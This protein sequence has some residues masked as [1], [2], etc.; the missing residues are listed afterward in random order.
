MP[1]PGY[2]P[3]LVAANGK[4]WNFIIINGD[5]WYRDTLRAMPKFL[6]NY[7]ARGTYYP[8]ASVN[9][10]LCFPGRAATY[11]GWRV[12]RHDAVNNGSGTRYVASGALANTIPVILE[13]A[14]YW[15]GFIGKIYNGL[16]EGGGGGWGALPWK[17]PG[18]HYMAGQW[19]APNYFD[20]EEL[21]ADGTIRMTHGTAD[22]N[23][24]GTDYA[25]DVERLRCVEFFD[26]VPAGRPWSLILATKGTHQ[27][28]GGVA[29]P[30]ARY[31]NTAVTLTEDASFGLDLTTVGHGSWSQ[32]VATVPWDA[33]AVTA[34]RLGHTEALRTALA[35]D[36]CVD[37]I[38]TELIARSWDQNTILIIKCDNAHSGGEG[39]FDAK[40]VPHQSATD[41]VMWVYVPG[42]PG[43]TCRAP[44]SDIDVAPFVY[45]MAGTAPPIA[46]HGMSF[47][48]T[49]FDKGHPHR[50]AAP[51]SNP[52]KDSPVF[53][54]IQ[55]GGN[56]GRMYYRILPTSAK[57]ANQVGGY[58]DA[59]QTKNVITPGDALVLA[60]LE[61]ARS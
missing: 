8:C 56:P 9:T 57:G 42:V 31:A 47:Y 5:D 20:W 34:A 30:P 25:V 49:L 16:G 41:S 44:V 21:Q 50:L 1:M 48:P 22:T 14:G 24:A 2:T 23:A 55:F 10:P 33:A 26:S 6:L 46:C 3:P 59:A 52:E 61:N 15:N 13:R 12:E 36:D 17:H 19:G 39:C 40:G 27:D 28:S 4:P 29:I 58:V 37:L 53:S 18:V 11:T 35:V 7:A 38:R 54:A 45:E 32:N 51:I 60:A 43:G